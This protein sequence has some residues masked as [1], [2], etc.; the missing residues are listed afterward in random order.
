MIEAER[1]YPYL[2]PLAS[3]YSQEAALARIQRQAEEQDRLN[4]IYRSAL[5]EQSGLTEAELDA[6]VSEGLS[7]EWPLPPFG[8]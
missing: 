1:S 7:K 4:E 3:G 6:I 8:E 2:D 5:G